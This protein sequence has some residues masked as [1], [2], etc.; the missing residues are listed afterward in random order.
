MNFAKFIIPGAIIALLGIGYFLFTGE[1]EV[2]QE[3]NLKTTVKKGDFVIEVSATG[4]LQ[5]KRSEKIRGPQGMRSAR[6]YQTSITDMIPEG[7]IVNEGDYVAT[8]DKTE[9]DGKMKETLNQIETTETQLAQTKIDTAIEM[10]GLRDQLINL[11]FAKEEKMLQLEQS[12]YEPQSVIRQAQIDLEKTSRDYEQLLQKYQLTEEKSEAQV[13][14]KLTSLKKDQLKMQQLMDLGNQ[15]RIIAP[16]SGMLIYARSWNGKI[17]PGSQ[18]STWDPVVA[19]LPDLSDMVSKTYVNEVDISKVKPGQE[20]KINVDAFPENEYYGQVIK[21]AN[22]GE[23]LKGY[24]SKVFEV[25]VQLNEVDSILRPAM[26][27][28]IE[29]VT[30]VYEDVL[31]IPLE[32]LQ[33]DSINFVYKEGADGKVVKQ[34]VVPGGTNSDEVMINLGLNYKDLVYLTIPKNASQLPFVYLD[35]NAKQAVK[36]EMDKDRVERDRVMRE[37][38][39]SVEGEKVDSDESGGGGMIIIG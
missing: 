14:E 1:Q 5:A 39:Q 26:T 24:D 34:E 17:G 19:E 27:T 28:G 7:T 16:K 4:E 29:I 25:I 22:I 37:K 31:F 36:L 2:K 18:I 35:E 21:V 9:L 15:F 13:K 23:Q 10:R 3:T 38:M 32:A 11:K 6:I 20:A 33:K 12:K 8:L 30:D